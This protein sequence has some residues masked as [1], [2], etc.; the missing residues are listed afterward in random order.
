MKSISSFN[1][2]GVLHAHSSLS[3]PP[4]RRG[5]GAARPHVGPWF[6]K[7]LS[8]LSPFSALAHETLFCPL[9]GVTE[10]QSFVFLQPKCIRLLKEKSS[11]SQGL[12]VISR[13]SYYTLEADSALLPFSPAPP[14]LVLSVLRTAG[15][16]WVFSKHPLVSRP[17]ELLCGLNYL[18]ILATLWP[19]QFTNSTEFESNRVL[20]CHSWSLH[21]GPHL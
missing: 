16:P 10:R 17:D 1:T 8:F 11:Y 7:G 12:D 13:W 15:S 2:P 9:Q 18:D 5:K 19:Q 21:L 20:P 3:F 6:P 14:L 4:N